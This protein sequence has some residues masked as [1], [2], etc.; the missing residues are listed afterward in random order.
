M[1]KVYLG[2]GSNV[3]DRHDYLIKAQA[4][5]Q[6][7]MGRI[8]KISSILETESWGFVSHPFLNQVILIETPLTPI[9]LLNRI[10]DIEKRLGRTEKTDLL[11]A[12]I[13]Y[14]ARTIDI[15]MLI[16]GDLKL[17]T[18]QLKLPHPHMKE[19]DF[20]MIPLMEIADNELIYNI[21][22]GKI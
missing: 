4:L 5:I 12:T 6:S 10:N 17:D 9:E 8:I 18:A 20:V 7:E 14:H 21:K 13:T 2:L 15:D 1:T 19:R 22:T 3:G 11:R 16:F